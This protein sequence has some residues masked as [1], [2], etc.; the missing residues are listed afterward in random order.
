MNAPST[1]SPAPGRRTYG[2]AVCQFEPVLF[3]KAANLAKIEE[4]AGAATSGGARLAIFP[5]CC[6]TGYAT[7]SLAPRM[8]ELAEPALDPEPGPSARRLA[9]LATQ[10]HL[11]LLVGLPE[12]AGDGTVYNSAVSFVPGAGATTAFHKVHLWEDDIDAFAAGDRFIAAEAPHGRLGPLI[13]Y[14]LDF[15]EAARAVVLMGAELVAVCTA[16]MRPWQDQQRIFGQARAAENEAYVAIAN[17]LGTVEGSE[18]FGAST[19]VDPLGRVLAEADDEEAVLI[20]DVDLDL[21]E[22]V[23][24]G[25]DY[26]GR[27]RPETYGRD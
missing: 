23:R 7:G 6:V 9:E 16:N 4:L 22:E 14:D 25:E 27:R 10:L 12:R 8:A 19:I 2:V 3:D 1:H 5:E 17:C 21:I 20:A 18:F 13:C 15:P 24:A 11:Q 26:L